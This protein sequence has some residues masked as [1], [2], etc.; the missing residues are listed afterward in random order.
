MEGKAIKLFTSYFGNQRKLRAAGCA[1]VSIARYNPKFIHDLDGWCVSVAPTSAMLSMS[2][3][4]YDREMRKIL[5]KVDAGKIYSEITKRA[6]GHE[7]VALCCY[8]KNSNECHRQLVA[9]WLTSC[10]YECKEFGASAARPT[11][12]V[13]EQLNML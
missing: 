11:G 5:S 13:T 8:E 9:R 12:P 7:A 2:P 6:N 4:A 10:G 1:I 3:E